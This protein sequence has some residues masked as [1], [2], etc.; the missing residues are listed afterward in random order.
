MYAPVNRR[1]RVEP[2]DGRFVTLIDVSHLPSG[3][4]SV[5]ALAHR[6]AATRPCAIATTS[7]VITNDQ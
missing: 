2:A 5:L 7:L 1:I 4:Y 6:G 3:R